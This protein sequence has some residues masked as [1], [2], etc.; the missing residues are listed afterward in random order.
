MDVW[1]GNLTF[2][3]RGLWGLLSIRSFTKGHENKKV[4]KIA[5]S[6]E[7]HSSLFTCLASPSPWHMP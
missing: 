2:G 1:E 6:S 7:K 4:G 3:Q 5:F